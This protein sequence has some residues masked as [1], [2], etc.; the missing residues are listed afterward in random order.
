MQAELPQ[1]SWYQ[2]LVVTFDFAE[3]DYVKYCGSPSDS[4]A[5]KFSADILL[6]MDCIT[7]QL[8]PLTHLLALLC[9]HRSRAPLR[10]LVRSL[11]H[12]LRRHVGKFEKLVQL[13]PAIVDV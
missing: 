1:M 7:P 11:A 9:S 4:A 10:S 5:A 6:R 8:A 2:F 13:S 12:L 3:N